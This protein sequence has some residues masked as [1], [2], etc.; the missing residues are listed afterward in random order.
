MNDILLI[1]NDDQLRK[2]VIYDLNTHFALKTLGSVSYF[3]GFEA[4]RS[5]TGFVLTQKKYTRDLLK[6]VPI[7]CALIKCWPYLIVPYLTH[8]MFTKVELALFSI[9]PYMTCLD[10]A[11]AVNK[12]SQLLVSLQ[13][14][15]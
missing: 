6:S 13:A 15:S 5:E 8:L 7:L 4:A 3:P 14:G 11:F 2:Q 10:I 9:L 12:L 1:G